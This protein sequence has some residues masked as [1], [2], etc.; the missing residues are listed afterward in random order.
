MEIQLWNESASTLLKIVDDPVAASFRDARG[1][2]GSGS[3]TVPLTEE[4]K[5]YF[6][7]DLVVKHVQDGEAVFAWV[8]EEDTVNPLADPP[9]VTATGR[10]ILC[11]LEWATVYPARGLRRKSKDER[12]F[13]FGSGDMFED[14]LGVTWWSVSENERTAQLPS[15]WPT[16]SMW[17]IWRYPIGPDRPAGE[18]VWFKRGITTTVGQ[19]VRIDATADGAVDLWVDDEKVLSVDGTDQAN[20]GARVMQTVRIPLPAGDH[21]F[22]AKG[23]N[24]SAPDVI[25]AGMEDAGPAWIA[26]RIAKVTSDDVNDA[27]EPLL[28]TGSFGWQATTD[29]PG[30]TVGLSL[31]LMLSEAYDRNVD[32]QFWTDFSYDND[33]DSNGVAWP[34]NVN[35]SWPVGTD[36]LEFVLDLR[37]FEADVWAT[38]DKVL[39]AAQSR[40]VDRSNQVHLFPAANLA[41]YGVK[42][43]HRVR[44]TAAVNT[45]VGWAEVQDADALEDRGRAETRIDLDSIDSI[46]QA[47]RFARNALKVLSRPATETD[48]DKTEVIPWEGATPYKDFGLADIVGIPDGTAVAM[49][50]TWQLSDTGDQWFLELDIAQTGARIM[51]QRQLQKMLNIARTGGAA[52]SG[53]R[54]RSATKKKK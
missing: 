33:V 19:T 54:I 44:T 38:P 36:L 9:T 10:G 45:A 48:G 6:T 7:R 20:P 14:A 23:R 49:G 46:P 1:E 3:L 51:S 40:G 32:R 37:E 8:I 28:L 4:Y 41:S 5:D 30:W 31:N 15:G 50:I 11:W 27:G 24:H 16:P 29:E 18:E 42:R 13:G 25:A 12:V 35:R 2:A 53:G 43:T 21:W 17:Q 34:H 39:H 47:I 52:S 26:I 22:M